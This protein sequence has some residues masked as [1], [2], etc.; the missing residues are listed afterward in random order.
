MVVTG[1][2]GL[3]QVTAEQAQSSEEDK[4]KLMI[5]TSTIATQKDYM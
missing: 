2:P 4:Q 3:V 1:M 5:P